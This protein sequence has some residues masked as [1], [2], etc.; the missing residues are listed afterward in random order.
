MVMVLISP[1]G[2]LKIKGKSKGMAIRLDLRNLKLQF[3]NVGFLQFLLQ[4]MKTANH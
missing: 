4:Y 2:E 1:V 3:T